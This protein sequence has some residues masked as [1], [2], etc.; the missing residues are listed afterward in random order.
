MLPGPTNVPNRVINAMLTP[1][2]NHRSDDFRKLYK[3]IISK[4]QKVFETENDIVVLTT[5]GTGAVE[6]SV[7]NLIKKDDVVIIP[8]NGEFS[9]RLADL[10]DNYGGKTIRIN[11][12]YGK[13]PPIEKIQDA[14][15]KNSKVKALYVVYNE[16]STGTT[17]RYLSK[18]GDICKAHGAFFVVD[19]VSILGGDELP[20][21]KWNVDICF[22]ATQKALAAPPGIAPISI[23]KEA[24]KYMI[25]NPPASQYLNLKRYFKYYNDSFE[26][27]FT[28]AISLFYAYQEALNII[29]EEG[30]QNRIERHRKC[31]NAFYSGLEAL[32]FTPFADAN[33]RSNVVIA[34]NYLPG[35]DDKRFRELI[36]SKFKVLLA[37]GFGELKGK[38]FRVGCMGEVSSYHVMRTL[39]AI[40]SSMSILGVPPIKDGLSVANNILN[41]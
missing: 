14:F 35:I 10:I 7:V 12:P 9:T 5:S 15:E 27:P 20:V 31:A 38:V 37:G 3:D 24:K 2:I 19:A 23:S 11:S 34:V 25:E 29:L 30:I 17:L 26:T 33:S 4:T 22:T 32:G 40:S 6:T 41:Q 13:N 28:P 36:S 18:L 16:T 8:V 39:S 21:D 1:M